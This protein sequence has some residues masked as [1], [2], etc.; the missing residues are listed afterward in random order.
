[1]IAS[2]ALLVST[3]GRVAVVPVRCWPS[4]GPRRRQQSFSRLLTYWEPLRIDDC[5]LLLVLAARPLTASLGS[6]GRQCTVC[7]VCHLIPCHRAVSGNQSQV[8][9]SQGQSPPSIA[10]ATAFELPEPAESAAA[11]TYGSYAQV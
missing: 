3:T 11:D 10:T 6:L 2:L 7:S 1:M 8:S 4:S 9:T 5:L